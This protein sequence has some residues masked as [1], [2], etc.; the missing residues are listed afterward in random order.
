LNFNDIVPQADSR[1]NAEDADQF[2]TLFGL[3]DVQG[4][5]QIAERGEESAYD[6]N[7][8]ISARSGRV[9]LDAMGSLEAL[10]ASNPIG[11]A[12]PRRRPDMAG[13]RKLRPPHNRSL[14][15]R[16][17]PLGLTGRLFAGSVERSA[18]KSQ[19]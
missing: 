14:N 13:I 10:R 11:V 17:P 15:S 2:S 6:A 18:Q 9:L 4:Y 7:P 19:G 8:K 3:T 12:G 1:L 5:E 16:N